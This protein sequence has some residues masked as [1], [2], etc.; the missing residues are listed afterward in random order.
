M[1]TQAVA[2]HRPVRT[3]DSPVALSS[4]MGPRHQHGPRWHSCHSHQHGPRGNDAQGIKQQHRFHMFTRISGFV[5]IWG[6]SMDTDTNMASG[7]FVDHSGPSRKSNPESEP[8]LSSDLTEMFLRAR[9]SCC[10]AAG[11]GVSLYLHKL[12]SI[13]HHPSDPTGQ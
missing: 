2:I 10:P 11:L 8:F 6:K 13:V 9:G 1:V 3:T 12:Q 4:C 5:M 7:G